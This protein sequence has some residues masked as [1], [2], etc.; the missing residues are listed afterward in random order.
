M[1][2]MTGSGRKTSV[3]L[4]SDTQIRITREFAAPQH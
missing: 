3:G 1:T 4:P 2:T